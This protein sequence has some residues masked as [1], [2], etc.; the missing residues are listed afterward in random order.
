MTTR[1]LM[2]VS[3]VFLGLLGVAFIFLPREL[4]DYYGVGSNVVAV[5]VLQVAGAR[6]LDFAIQNWMARA[7][8]IIGVIYSRPVAVRNFLHIAIVA[9]VFLRAMV[10]GGLP[11]ELMPIGALHAVFTALFGWVVFGNP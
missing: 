2:S 1:L 11:G 4:L 9:S 7:D 6:Y 3:V 5:L 8:P 10:A